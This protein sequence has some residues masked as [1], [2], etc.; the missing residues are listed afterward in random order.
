MTARKPTA[1]DRLMEAHSR[2]L[3]SVRITPGMPAAVQDAL[4][5]NADFIES[6]VL[7]RLIGRL[8][9]TVSD[10]KP[11]SPS[12]LAQIVED[13]CALGEKDAADLI[14]KHTPKE[15]EQ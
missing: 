3:A 4:V 5:S 2:L 7:A 12:R 10:G 11:I 15:V 6:H 1:E 13:M 9:G 14:A 8:S